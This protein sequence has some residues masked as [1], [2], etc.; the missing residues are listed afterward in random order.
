MIWYFQPYLK[1]VGV[2]IIYF[3]VIY[4]AIGLVS[5]IS[6]AL[7]ASLEK[8]TGK[9][10]YVVMTMLVVIPMFILGSFPGLLA[11]PLWFVFTAFVVINQTITSGHVLRII[12]SGQSATIL[13]FQNLLRRLVYAIA[14]PLM[15]IVADKSG[16][17]FAIKLNAL[18]I[19]VSLGVLLFYQAKKKYYFQL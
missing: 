19:L 17:L 7:T 14:G 18:I 5:A 11:I 9:Y 8:F 4:A 1:M 12:S 10:I 2:P 3:G 6:V 15:G 13:S 16:I